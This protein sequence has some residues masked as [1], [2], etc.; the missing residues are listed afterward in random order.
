MNTNTNL[1]LKKD[2]PE[3]IPNIKED[4]I[5][6]VKPK[7]VQEVPK[8]VENV[9][10]EPKSVNSIL[11]AILIIFIIVIVGVIVWIIWK[12]PGTNSN[13]LNSVR[14]DYE[15][16]KKELITL[17]NQNKFLKDNEMNLSKENK[18]LKDELDNYKKMSA[19]KIAANHTNN[20]VEVQDVQEPVMN[21]TGKKAKSFKQRKQELYQKVSTKDDEP[22]ENKTEVMQFKTNVNDNL[23]ANKNVHNYKEGPTK[24]DRSDES[25]DIDITSVFN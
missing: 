4:D 7:I 6:E 9:H 5:L 3:L 14:E 25:E 2:S 24:Q 8:I 18:G 22:C 23:A 21:I 13:V 17:K 15:R 12:K 1:Q 10:I 11:T 19:P 16:T 20:K